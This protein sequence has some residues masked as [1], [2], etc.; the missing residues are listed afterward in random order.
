MHVCNGLPQVSC[1]VHYIFSL[2]LT[3]E[4]SSDHF[5][6]YDK[7]CTRHYNFY[8]L[9]C[10]NTVDTI[11]RKFLA[12]VTLSPFYEGHKNTSNLG[13]V[14]KGQQVLLLKHGDVPNKSKNTT[15]FITV[16]VTCFD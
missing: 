16:E 6:I 14:F 15:I 11:K 9:L 3:Y 5:D 13:P 1:S 2:M 10:K 12:M 7:Y 4:I 8:K